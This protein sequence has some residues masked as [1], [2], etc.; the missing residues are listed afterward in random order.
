MFDV[1]TGYTGS[2]GGLYFSNDSSVSAV[3]MISDDI[4]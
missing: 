4:N 1:E 2:N 3:G